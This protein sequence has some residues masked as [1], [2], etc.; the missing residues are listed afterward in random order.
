M[1]LYKQTPDSLLKAGLPVLQA[2]WE[3]VF[4]PIFPGLG[5]QLWIAG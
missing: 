1:D 4:S 5:T 3:E 2:V